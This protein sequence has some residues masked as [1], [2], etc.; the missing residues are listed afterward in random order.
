MSKPRARRAMARPMRPRPMIPMVLPWTKAPAKW[1]DCEPGNRPPRSAAS[2]STTRR[3]AENG[4]AVGAGE[5]PH[6]GHGAPWIE[7]A[8]VESI[9]APDDYPVLSHQVDE[10]AQR[11]LVVDDGVVVEP[12]QVA[13]GPA[14]SLAARLPADAE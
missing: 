9:I 14:A 3:A 8:H 1:S 2:A 5:L 11:E 10:V 12:P 4:G 6:R 7:A 13:A